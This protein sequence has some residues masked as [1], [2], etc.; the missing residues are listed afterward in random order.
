M[1]AGEACNRLSRPAEG[2]QPIRHGDRAERRRMIL[3]RVRSPPDRRPSPSQRRSHRGAR[4]EPA[5]KRGFDYRTSVHEEGLGGLGIS[6]GSR[7]CA[8][9]QACVW[10]AALDN[11]RVVRDRGSSMGGFISSSGHNTT[12]VSTTT[13]HDIEA[14]SRPV[15]VSVVPRRRAAQ[16]IVAMKHLRASL[17]QGRLL[18]EPE[19]RKRHRAIV[20]LLWAHAIGLAVFGVLM[21]YEPLHSIAEAGLVAIA[22]VIAG[23]RQPSRKVRAGVAS[24][25][26]IT[27]S[28]LLVHFWGG[29]IEGHFHFFF[30]IGVLTLYQD[31]LPFILAL[32][33][34]VLHHGLLGAIDP[35]SVYNHPAAVADPW[36]WAAVH[37][38][39]VVATSIANLVTWRVNEDRLAQSLA[40]TGPRFRDG[41]C[42]LRRPRPLQA[43][44]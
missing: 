36:L 39:F 18:P 8:D 20:A 10:R 16:A 41:G 30:V 35:G 6:T 15:L 33:Y 22:A 32:V 5:L 26:L 42:D 31:W 27:S 3:P 24:W 28:A 14:K 38:V 29:A 4:S 23:L 44:Q 7:R 37:A 17:P 40:A 25:G 21:G 12:E 43:R 2:G 9:Q 13:L 19:W 34:V 11:D 1:A